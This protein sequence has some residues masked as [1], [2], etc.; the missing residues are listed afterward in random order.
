MDY[1]FKYYIIDLNQEWHL[2]SFHLLVVEV[3]LTLILLILL[4]L[5]LESEATLVLSLIHFFEFSFV[6]FT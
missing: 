5:S 2:R 1:I 6:V 3:N 4:L